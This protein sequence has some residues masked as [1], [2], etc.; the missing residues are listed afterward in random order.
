MDETP[1]PEKVFRSLR[2]FHE[3]YYPSLCPDCAHHWKHHKSL[4]CKQPKAFDTPD[5]FG[6]RE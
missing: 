5:G 1:A 4:G 6:V 2:E 3:A